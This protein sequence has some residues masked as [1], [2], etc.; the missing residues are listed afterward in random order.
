MLFL[1]RFYLTEGQA[2]G[3]VDALVAAEMENE[4]IVLLTPGDTGA[5]AAAVRAGG[6]LGEHAGFYADQLGQGHSLV[7]VNPAFGTSKIVTAILEEHN[8]LPITHEPAPEPFVPWSEKP[9]AFSTLLGLPVL[10]KSDTPFSDFWG[11]KT[12][13]EGTSHFSRW[14]KPLSPGFTFSSM[15]GMSFKTSGDTPLSSM[16]GM[17]TSSSRND[18]KA[19][20]FGM[21]FKT[22][23]STP[24]SSM[25]GLPLLTKRK[26]FLY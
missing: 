10:T 7:V 9:A 11:L 5:A 21:S 1:A 17:S 18:G 12:S 26:H 16:V 8:P 20:S 25:F 2:R 4:R 24:F 22:K 13:Q 15:L 3:A 6:M 14:L 19:G 23:G